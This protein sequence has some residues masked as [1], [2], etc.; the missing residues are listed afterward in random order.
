MIELT[1]EYI[2]HLREVIE[3]KDETA[4]VNMLQELYPADIA[5][6]FRNLTWKK[7]SISTCLWMERR[8]PMF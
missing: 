6:Y 2:E 4:A 8:R 3:L 7:L 1:K 5:S